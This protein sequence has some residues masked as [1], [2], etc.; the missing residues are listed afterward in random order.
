MARQV[1]LPS[2]SLNM[3][4]LIVLAPPRLRPAAT[5]QSSQRCLPSGLVVSVGNGMEA[6]E[7]PVHIKSICDHSNGPYLVWLIICLG[8]E[9]FGRQ[10]LFA[11]LAAAHITRCVRRPFRYQRPGGAEDS[12]VCRWHL[13]RPHGTGTAFQKDSRLGDALTSA[14]LR[15]RS[16]RRLPPCGLVPRV[17]AAARVTVM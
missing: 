16:S 11:P 12:I 7:E 15:R 5:K 9:P 6:R 14:A 10:L 1:T 13:H 4:V 17:A 8:E 2:R 3:A